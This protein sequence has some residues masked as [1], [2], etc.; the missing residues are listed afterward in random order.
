MVIT[1]FNKC[2]NIRKGTEFNETELEY[3]L[4]EKGFS[5]RYMR[6]VNE[7][8]DL[9]WKCFINERSIRDTYLSRE[10]ALANVLMTYSD[11]FEEVV[12]E[13]YK[14]RLEERITDEDRACYYKKLLCMY[15]VGCVQLRGN[16]CVDTPAG[17]V[18]FTEDKGDVEELIKYMGNSRSSV[19][20]LDSRRAAQKLRDY[21][22]PEYR[23]LELV[24]FTYS[25]AATD[26][27]IGRI[28]TAYINCQAVVDGTPMWECFAFPVVEK[29]DRKY[30]II[31]SGSIKGFTLHEH[32]DLE[33]FFSKEE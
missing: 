11:T 27:N 28:G 2:F 22:D 9:A 4:L 13:V 19:I 3:K 10:N 24:K 33:N 18:W 20:W 30:I 23:G 15:G 32:V 31:E 6:E 5:V 1:D 26:K 16:T 17:S 29:F 25:G 12:E 8:G 21:V 7:D 14:V